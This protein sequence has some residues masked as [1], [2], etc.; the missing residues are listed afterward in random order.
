MQLQ[1][2]GGYHKK[3]GDIFVGMLGSMNNTYILQISN[4][5]QR[6]MHGDLFWQN[7]GGKDIWSYI[8]GDKVYPLLPWL[9]W[10]CTNKLETCT[11]LG[12][13]FNKHLIKGKSVVEIVFGILKKTFREL[14]L[15][16][17]L[18]IPFVLIVV[19][20]CILYNMIIN[21]KDFDL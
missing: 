15:K 4:L 16:T 5:Y 18:H 11:I 12:A 19:V 6:A 7:W 2:I 8:F 17:N 3:I 20:C 14:I 1:V 9:I 13:L 10:S 21:G